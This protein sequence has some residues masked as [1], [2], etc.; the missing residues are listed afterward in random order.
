MEPLDIVLL[1][2]VFL[3][4][5]FPVAFVW[6]ICI[7]GIYIAI[8]EK[9]LAGVSLPSTIIHLIK[10]NNIFV[11]VFIT[12]IISLVPFLWMIVNILEHVY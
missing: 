3:V 9:R 11:I 10:S 6:Y 5:L 8:K 2:F 12:T 7:G 1:T 4:V